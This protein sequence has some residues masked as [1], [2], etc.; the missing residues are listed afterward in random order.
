MFAMAKLAVFLNMI[1]EIAN[2]KEIYTYSLDVMKSL[3]PLNCLNIFYCTAKCESSNLILEA[4][5]L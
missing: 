4:K 3:P 5:T 1:E 2:P